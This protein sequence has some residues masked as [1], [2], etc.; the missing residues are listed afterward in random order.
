MDKSILTDRER[1]YVVNSVSS[2]LNSVCPSLNA[3]KFL[4]T[5]IYWDKEKYCFVMEALRM[6]DINTFKFYLELMAIGD[7]YNKIKGGV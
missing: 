6:Y 3:Q 5:V 4:D 2:Y 7:S 1:D